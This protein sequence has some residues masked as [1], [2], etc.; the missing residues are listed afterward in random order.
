MKVYKYKNK[1]CSYL[2]YN[3]TTALGIKEGDELEFIEFNSNAFLVSRKSDILNMI[4]QGKAINTAVQEPAAA[5]GP[6]GL[7]IQVL[8]KIDTLRYNDRTKENVA[9]LLNVQEKEILVQM[10]KK[11]YLKPF[12]SKQGIEVYS[13]SKSIYDNFLMRKTQAQK[14]AKNDALEELHKEVHSY[15][16]KSKDPNDEYI[17][18]LSKDGYIVLLSE[19]EASRVSMLL[20]QSIR[21][22]EILG[23]RAFNKKFYIVLRDYLNIYSPAIIKELKEGPSKAE[24]IARK[25]KV[26]VDG[27]KAILYLLAE[28]GEI[29]EKKKDLFAIA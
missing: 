21:H 14:P 23:T 13:I 6:S 27:A 5:K 10:V 29:I 8:K 24:E 7:E 2:P 20:E 12:K 1:L 16:V 25:A 4:M 15:N 22:G 19:S 17:K 28:S 26:D 11:D 18:T 3:V 9:K